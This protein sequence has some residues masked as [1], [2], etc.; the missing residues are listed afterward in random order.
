M[1]TSTV[2]NHNTDWIVDFGA[3]HHISSNFQN[4]SMHSK[5]GGHDD[6]IIGDGN[7]VLITHI[8]YIDF[9]TSQSKF[10]LNNCLCAP[11]FFFFKKKIS[12]LCPNFASKI[13]YCFVV[14]DLSTRAS[15]IQGPNKG[16]V[17]EWP[18]SSNTKKVVRIFHTSNL[19]S[20]TS[21]TVL[22]IHQ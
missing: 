16:H 10:H 11:N 3:S 17:Y 19:W 4:L 13:P 1:T 18:S 5:Y 22:V 20:I 2:D 14:K 12:Y 15:L 8:G 9:I 21:I 7:Q 6:I